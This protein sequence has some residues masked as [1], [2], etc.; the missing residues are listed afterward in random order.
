M[1]S[2]TTGIQHFIIESVGLSSLCRLLKIVLFYIKHIYG[3]IYLSPPPPLSLSLSLSLPFSLS[4]SLF[5]SFSLSL[6]LSFSLSL[7]FSLSA[8]L[9]LS[10]S[11]YLSVYLSI[12]LSVYLPVSL[13]GDVICTPGGTWC[14][15]GSA[16]R[17]G[18]ARRGAGGGLRLATGLGVA[19]RGGERRRRR[20]DV[21]VCV[22]AGPAARKAGACLGRRRFCSGFVLS[23]AATCAAVGG[24]WLETGGNHQRR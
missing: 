21:G 5:L 4:L 3:M 20:G 13:S 6:F 9:S 8:F 17:R 11:L 18:G 12:Y 24:R 2:F 7:H 23:C 1:S 16:A 15:E 19:G 14:G 10:V 22:C